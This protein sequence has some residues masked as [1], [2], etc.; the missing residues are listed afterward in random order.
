MADTQTCRTG[1]FG[2]TTNFAAAGSSKTICRTPF[3]SSTSKPS[4]SASGS[5]D[6]CA[7]SS[8]WSACRR[9]SCSVSVSV[10]RACL[11]RRRQAIGGRDVGPAGARDLAGLLHPQFELVLLAV[12]R[13]RREPDRVEAVQLLRDAGKGGRELVGLLQLEVAAAGLL[14]DFL[15]RSIGL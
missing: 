12:E 3:C 13:R 11:I 8:A 5:S 6:R 4:S 15:Q 1:A 7:C 10:M 14:G 2:L 9:K